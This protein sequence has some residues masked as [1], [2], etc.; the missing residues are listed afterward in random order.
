MEPTH[1]LL[2]SGASVF[3]ACLCSTCLMTR[4]VPISDEPGPSQSAEDT[5][6]MKSQGPVCQVFSKE[7][8][9]RGPMRASGCSGFSAF[10]FK[11]KFWKLRWNLA[12]SVFEVV[13]VS[14][15]P[16][17]KTKSNW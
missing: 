17:R 1:L 3:V 16:L 7:I 11:V 9:E 4:Q 13:G 15:L 10:S 14:G 12:S 5:M 8:K 2:K 6:P